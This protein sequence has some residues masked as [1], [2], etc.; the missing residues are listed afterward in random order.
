MRLVTSGGIN[1][2]NSYLFIYWAPKSRGF[3]WGFGEMLL[4]VEA[5]NGPARALYQRLGYREVRI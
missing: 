1:I 5:A 3:R 2:P 4:L